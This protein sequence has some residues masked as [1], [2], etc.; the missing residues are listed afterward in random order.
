MHRQKGK[1]LS[2]V[3]PLYNNLPCTVRV[4]NFETDWFSVTQG[5]KQDCVISPT[6]FSIYVNDLAVELDSLNYGVS[7]QEALNISVLLYADDIAILSETEAGMQT[8][9]NKFDD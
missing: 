1:F 7:L 3:Q 5:V 6:L 8:M 9:L 4:N 2:A